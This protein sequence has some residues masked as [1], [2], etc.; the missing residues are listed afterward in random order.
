VAADEGASQAAVDAF[1]GHIAATCPST[2]ASDPNGTTAQQDV[3]NAFLIEAGLE[4]GLTELR[5]R[6]TA[7]LAYA[8]RLDAL[9]WKDKLV[10]RAVASTVRQGRRSLA[11]SPPDMCVEVAAAAAGGFATVPPATAAFLG[12]AE[13]TLTGSHSVSGLLLLMKPYIT[14]GEA[15]TVSRLRRLESHIRRLE[16]T[17]GQGAANRMVTAL[18]GR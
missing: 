15:P 13:S 7:A 2:L 5:A 6:Q 14:P 8:G 3:A 17:F 11:L 9:H 4:L 12:A 18:L 10:N 1:V 16:A